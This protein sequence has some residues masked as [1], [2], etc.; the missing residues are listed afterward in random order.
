MHDQE[1]PSLYSK[2]GDDRHPSSDRSE[3]VLIPKCVDPGNSPR[4]KNLPVVEGGEEEKESTRGWRN[5][6]AANLGA[7]GH[8]Q[9]E[10]GIRM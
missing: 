4:K 7:G 9:L 3:F 2:R 6:T 10:Q 5:G 8:E 1:G